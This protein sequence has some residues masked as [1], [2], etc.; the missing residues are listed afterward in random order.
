MIPARITE[1]DTH[2][3]IYLILEQLLCWLSRFWHHKTRKGRI[4]KLR[5]LQFISGF[6]RRTGTELMLQFES[7]SS[8]SKEFKRSI[9]IYIEKGCHHA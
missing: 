2:R 8:S 5:S 3:D 6:R 1:R 7:P 9:N 4:Y